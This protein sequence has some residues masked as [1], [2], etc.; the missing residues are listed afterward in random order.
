MRLCNVK[1]PALVL[2]CALPMVI[3]AANNVTVYG[4]A[5][6]SV[7]IT[8]NG[9]ENLNRVSSNGSRLGFKGSEDLGDGLKA[10]FQLETLVIIDNGVESNGLLFGTG[11]NSF[12]GLAGNLGTAFL[13]LYDTPYK[14]ATRV[15]LWG[16]SMGDYNTIIGDVISNSTGNEFDRREPETINYF[17]PR[18]NGI[19]FKGQYRPDEAAGVDTDRYSASLSYEADPWMASVS[20]AAHKNESSSFAARDALPAI[21]G[22]KADTHGLKFGL[23]Y[24]FNE[25]NTK[26]ALVYETLDQESAATVFDRDAWY[27]ALS[28]KMGNN[29]FKVAYA[30]ADENDQTADSGASF[31]VLGLSH[32]MGKRTELFA[33]Y[34]ATNNDTN[35]RYGIGLTGGTGAVT[36]ASVGA[37]L[38]TFSVGMNIDF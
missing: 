34:A 18:Y 13:G 17:S 7:D 20:Y 10:V 26:L 2:A 29:T 6:A 14:E 23:S 21:T 11:R 31:Y 8:D 22:V 9:G 38:S 32:K 24:L 5:R 4:K 36:P 3:Q 27:L 30:Q 16:D 25:D 28:H 19:Q 35:G 12:V 37:D 33:L 1:L 15:D